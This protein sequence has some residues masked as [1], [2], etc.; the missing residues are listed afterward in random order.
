MRLGPMG[1]HPPRPFN[2]HTQRFVTLVDALQECS[3]ED[4][5][6]IKEVQLGRMELMNN[7]VLWSFNP[8]QNL[9]NW[10]EVLED[11]EIDPSTQYRF[12]ELAGSSTFGRREAERILAHLTKDRREEFKRSPAAWLNAVI[13]EALDALG[14]PREWEGE[15]QE[16]S[17]DYSPENL[18]HWTRTSPR[19]R[20]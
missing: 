14:D 19:N 7:P 17:R 10:A 13:D 9:G 16:Y 18:P 1:L 15:G 8:P 2:L 5:E 6:R 4:Y 3:P 11:C 20:R 12:F